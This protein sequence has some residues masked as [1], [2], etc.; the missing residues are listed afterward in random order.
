MDRTAL[1]V[2]AG[3]RAFLL[4]L[5]LYARYATGSGKSSS[6]LGLWQHWDWYRY[7]T[8]AEYGYTS[9]KGPSYDQNITAFLPGFPLVLHAVQLAVRD[10]AVSGLLISL[11]AGA[12]AV[13]ALARLTEF[14]YSRRRPEG[15]PEQARRAARCAVLLLVCA[16]AAVFLAA[17]YTE[18]LFLAFAVPGW[19]AA[20]RGQW[21]KASVLIAA[22]CTIRVN[23]LFVLAGVAVMFLTSRPARRDRLRAP[24][25]LLPLAAAGAYA[26][27]LKDITGDWL[28]WLHAEKRGWSRSL[29]NPI[30]AWRTS[31][32]NAF[33]GGTG[34]G[35][36]GGF[37]SAGTGGG[38]GGRGFGGGGNGSGFPGGGNGGPPQF[39]GGGGGGGRS[40]GFGAGSGNATGAGHLA[41]IGE[42]DVWAYRFELIA[43]VLGIATVL[44]LAGRRRWAELCYVG[45]SVF[46]L[47]TSTSYM[48]IPREM[49]LW[50][51]LW[52][53]AAIWLAARRWALI[54]ACAAS[55]VLMVA[56]AL[57]YFSGQWAG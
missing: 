10:W 21:I 30:K 9:G 35:E 4:S 26:A 24:A 44:C 32:D 52:V 19:L 39:G 42:F 47:V 29:T 23:G 28:E 31:W 15:S 48:S 36:N 34:F 27:Y 18:S 16:P 49:L 2:W 5:S 43:A 45:I 53:G 33:G 14:E 54:A 13:V 51:P 1:A 41:G 17:G 56:T 8:V 37:P 22:A 20:R 25:L 6:W 7:L 55:G 50:W 40:G 46:A 11:V 12:V 38:S 3:S 57:L